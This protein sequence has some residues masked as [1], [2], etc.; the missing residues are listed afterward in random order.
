MIINRDLDIK[1][2]LM[3]AAIKVVMSMENQKASE[4]IHGQMGSFMKG[5][6]S[7]DSNMV[8]ECGKVSKVI[9]M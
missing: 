5:N 7:M 1:S 8:L 4:S 6:G 2:F 9:A 3:A